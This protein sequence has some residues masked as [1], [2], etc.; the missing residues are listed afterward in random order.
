MS[1][2]KK[3]I[4]TK[5]KS[6]NARNQIVK[7]LRQI[8]DVL[9]DTEQQEE[10]DQKMLKKMQQLVRVLSKLLNHTH[11]D[12]RLLLSCCFVDIFRLCAPEPPCDD[13]T[14]VRIFDIIVKQLRRLKK[15]EDSSF[16]RCFYILESLS[17]VKS[18]LVLVALCEDSED[19]DCT[20]LVEL[21]HALLGSL[22]L[23]QNSKV[24]IY[25]AD[26]VQ[27][28]IEEFETPPRELLECV[29][30]YLVNG[31]SNDESAARSYRVV[32]MVL[33]QQLVQQPVQQYMSMLVQNHAKF[34]GKKMFSKNVNTLIREV[35]HIS[36]DLMIYALPQI[37]K[38]LKLPDSES[39]LQTA[40]LL[41]D[42][43]EDAASIVGATTFSGKNF[44]ELM[45]RCRD[46][47]PR[48]RR[49][50]VSLCVELM[51]SKNA[52]SL[53]ENTRS[54]VESKLLS[55][56]SDPDA[57]VRQGAAYDICDAA[58]SNLSR[59]S[60]SLLRAVAERVKDKK[61]TIARDAITGLVQVYRAWTYEEEEDEEDE[62][63][64]E[65]E[66]VHAEMS[67]LSKRREESSWK[68]KLSWIPGMLYMC[69]SRKED[70]VRDRV[71][72]LSDDILFPRTGT[73]L[74]RTLLLFFS[75]VFICHSTALRYFRSNR[76]SH[77]H[78]LKSTNSLNSRASQLGEHRYSQYDS[79]LRK[80]E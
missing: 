52:S 46:K 63:E 30:T 74:T 58:L 7:R 54:F 71:F 38:M 28:C 75:L 35:Y 8:H 31:S 78:T 9:K 13:E 56:L 14:T 70:V 32:Q 41:C 2:L 22:N 12:V 60:A 1:A 64:E 23:K 59:V 3:S 61:A 10:E 48:V 45:G 57:T 18:C 66:D 51:V 55:A 73:V 76:I 36:P 4:Q 16:E 53:S 69:L 80:S 26:I 43:Y 21:F 40:N 65:D 44:T 27:A 62:D 5:K 34:K 72:Q 42:M 17:D 68:S 79:S 49:R 19:K 29:L 25:V 47:D 37:T 15:N 39:R 67:R 11:D 33:K 24:D 50:L 6:T 20:R 77:T